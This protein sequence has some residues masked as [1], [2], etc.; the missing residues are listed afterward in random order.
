MTAKTKVTAAIANA[1]DPCEEDLPPLQAP[2][3][4]PAMFYGLVGDVMRAAADGTEVHPAAAGLA[5]MSFAGVA[6]G[7][8]R[9][10]QIG[11]TPHHARLYT[12]H[13]GRS[14]IAGKGMALA[15]TVRVRLACEYG[16]APLLSAL[17]GNFH[18]GGLSSRE[19]LAWLIRDA[20]DTNDKDGE[21]IDAGVSDKRLFVVEEELANVL[22]QSARDGNTLSAAIRSA[23][24]G[25]D[26]APA[27][28]TNRTRASKPHIGMHACITP[29]ELESALGTQELTNGFANRFLFCWAERRGIVPFPAATPTATVEALAQR[30]KGAIDHAATEGGIAVSAGAR[31][32]F[33]VF[34]RAHR[35][36]FG[37]SMLVRGLLERYPPYAWRLAL[38]FAL[39]DGL[40]EITEGH[41]NAALAWLAYCR[42]ST[43]LVFS[44]ATLEAEAG[45]A[46]ELG[47]KII[48]EI[49]RAG[50]AMDREPLRLAIGKPSKRDLDAALGQRI[51]AGEIAEASEPR[52]GGG[53][54][55]R[56]YVLKGAG[57]FG[58]FGRFGSAPSEKQTAD[59][60]PFV[61]VCSAVGGDGDQTV[62]T[63][64]APLFVESH[65]RQQ[66]A[67]TAQTS[68]GV[69]LSG[70]HSSGTAPCP[71]CDGEGCPYCNHVGMPG[72]VREEVDV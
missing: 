30:L 67:Q 16:R 23:W 32:R 18:D 11:D 57:K 7:R 3:V 17:A 24:D 25:H 9:Y 47:E 70:Q 68:G 50:G 8:N 64:E 62:Q 37:T 41:M 66:T 10:V 48:N 63:A 59:A 12:V 54:P 2:E 13:V 22:K 1:V 65:A 20:S 15:L 39:L 14:S 36:G 72:I 34:Y 38:L 43:T 5:F 33:A 29:G 35:H 31:D 56:R 46:A 55:L 40:D 49:T 27:T 42:E 58:Q 21:P 71:R 28:K 61:P 44:S 52:Q 19:G 26:I 4:T 69:S 53:R 60:A 51:D 6:L 45:D